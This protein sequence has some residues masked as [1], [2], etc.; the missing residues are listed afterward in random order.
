MRTVAKLLP[1]VFLSFLL[2]QGNSP[3]FPE[4]ERGVLILAHGGSPEWNKQVEE[5]VRKAGIRVPLEI[6]FGMGMMPQETAALQKALDKLQAAGVTNIRAVPL[7]VSSY[8]SVY[9]QYEYL[10][11]LR[12]TQSWPD[13]HPVSPAVL[14][15]GVRAEISPA[16]DDSPL[17]AEILLR[18]VKQLSRDP[19]G[20]AVLIVAHGPE[21]DQD[22]SAL[23]REME[24]LSGLIRKEGNIPAIELATLR[25]DAPPEVRKEATRLFR[26]Q[27]ERLSSSY[28][29][30]VVPLLI[31]RGGIEHK[32][33]ERLAG[34]RY[35]FSGEG[36]LPSPEISRWLAEQA[37]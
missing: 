13:H 37:S 18:R 30:I 2:F 29:V 5:A 11:G 4:G 24:S 34:L 15:P 9:R 6:V 14:K 22:N 7:L 16:L 31:S 35:V 8:S 32:I 25:D 19:R 21:T 1:A 36:L 26:A 20:E 33:N 27:V 23:L 12:P 10:L 3:V 28:R 17:V